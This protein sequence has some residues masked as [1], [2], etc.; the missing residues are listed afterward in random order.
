[1]STEA[2]VLLS[3]GIDSAACARFLCDRGYG[4]RGLF[5]DYGQ[6]AAPFEKQAALH[7]SGFLRIPLESLNVA[8]A[9]PLG[10]GEIVGRNAFLVFAAM[11]GLQLRSG[12]VALGIHSGTMY[13]DCT[14]AFLE[15]T[16]RLVA[17]YTDGRV[18]L[19]APFIAWSKKNVFDYYQASGMP[20][21]LSYSCEAGQMPPCGVCL[22]CRD[23]RMLG[24]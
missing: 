9:A 16:D 10:P 22:S 8:S 3:G 4:V 7:L 11:L 20:I 23:R 12:V 13:Y 5:V 19:V 18:R 2:V 17:E 24:C 14:P 1:M 15:A 6:K 21:E